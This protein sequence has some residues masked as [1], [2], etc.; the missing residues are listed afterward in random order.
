MMTF[1][2]AIACLV[3]DAKLYAAATFMSILNISMSCFA[4]LGVGFGVFPSTTHSYTAFSS[5]ANLEEVGQGVQQ[6]YVND[7]RYQATS[8]TC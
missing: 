6:G 2:R 1:L 4:S 8:T 7:M 5:S 3:I